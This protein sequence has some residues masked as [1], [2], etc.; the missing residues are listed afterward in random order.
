[1]LK[2]NK[3]AIVYVLVVTFILWFSP[4]S[5]LKYYYETFQR[6]SPEFFTDIFIRAKNEKNDDYEIF[7]DYSEKIII[8]IPSKYRNYKFYL[9]GIMI[10]GGRDVYISVNNEPIDS[11]Y[12]SSPQGMH[13]FF[14]KIYLEKNFGCYVSLRTGR[15]IIVIKSGNSKET[16]IV[17]LH[18]S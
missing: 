6:D 10:N 12:L 3:F 1:M 7:E 15:N 16:V 13:F 14:E 5:Y 2:E 11:V 4:F 8:N 17:N 18:S 9:G